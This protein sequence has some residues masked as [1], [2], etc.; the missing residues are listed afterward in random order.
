MRIGLDKTNGRWLCEQPSRTHTHILRTLRRSND[1]LVAGG[2]LLFEKKV[3]TARA[4]TTL[5]DTELHK[6]DIISIR[7]LMCVYI[8]AS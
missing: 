4:R 5:Y 3:K 1:L 7:M 2:G 6:I 8:T